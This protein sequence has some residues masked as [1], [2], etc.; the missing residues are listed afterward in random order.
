MRPG[1][2]LQSASKKIKMKS[3]IYSLA[4]AIS[5]LSWSCDKKNS[6]LVEP[7]TA[8]QFPQVILFDNEGDGDLEDA[9][10][11]SFSLT[12]AD[13]VDPEGAELGGTIVPL[14]EDVTI[15]FEIREWKGMSNPSA[16][17]KGVK[18][19]YEIDDCTT[20]ED[21]G[22]DLG[23]VFDNITGKGSVRFPKS[24]PEIEIVFETDDKLFDDKILNTEERSITLGITSVNAK[25]QNVT[26]NNALEFTYVILD[27][28]AI[29]GDWTV[30]HEDPS[31]FAAFKKLF[32]D[33][34][35]DIAK[36]DAGDI[37]KLQISFEYDEVKVTI[38]L[39]ETESVK[40]CGV[41][42]IVNKTIEL[43]ADLEALDLYT[44]NGE[45]AFGGEVEEEDDS[46]K[47]YSYEG[48]YQITGKNLKLI[49]SGEYDGDA[50]EEVTLLLER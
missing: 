43:E 48:D 42:E 39:K 30:D 6:D 46:I 21:K 24:I 9:D 35:P 28:E 13:R 15:A 45:I 32:S 40:E 36:L 10:E 44:N 3:G 1:S 33:V 34:L 16:Y 2:T 12:L 47:E 19:L 27:D 29:H 14:Q 4:I 20:S 17:I 5:L 26:F 38:E 37:D 7:Y 41:T 25:T 18:A 23:L 11:F 8:D 50:M 31:A 22:I 49:L